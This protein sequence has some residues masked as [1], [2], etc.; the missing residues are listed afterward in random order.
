MS[1]FTSKQ[2][3]LLSYSDEIDESE[4]QIGNTLPKHLINK[5]NMAGNNRKKRPIT[6][7]KYYWIS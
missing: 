1:I 5:H 3:G 6:I 4:A 2:G 7:R